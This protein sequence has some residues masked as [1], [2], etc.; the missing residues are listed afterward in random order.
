[1]FLR[2]NVQYI[3]MK[4][5]ALFFALSLVSISTFAQEKVK[6]T[7]EQVKKMEQYLFNEGFPRP[8]TKKS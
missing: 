6:S 8:S 5:K 7:K 3:T 4:I 2:L 1:M